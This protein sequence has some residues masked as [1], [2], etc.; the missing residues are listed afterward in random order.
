MNLSEMID[1]VIDTDGDGRA[2]VK[3]LI[4]YGHLPPD[5]DDRPAGLTAR[6]CALAEQ[7]TTKFLALEKE[8]L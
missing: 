2:V 6:Q 5:A 3:M 8:G 4:S 1:S 7:F